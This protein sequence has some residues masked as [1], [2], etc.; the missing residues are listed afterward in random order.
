MKLDKDDII[1]H[2]KTTYEETLFTLL[3]EKKI[4]NTTTL[5]ES[6]KKELY[7]IYELNTNE[8]TITS[9]GKYYIDLILE[10]LIKE[11]VCQ[12]YVKFHSYQ[13]ITSKFLKL[14]EL[15]LPEQRSPEWYA[16]REN[17][18][19]ASSLAD[20]LGKGHFQTRDELLLNKSSQ[21]KKPFISHWIMEWGVKYEDVAIQFYEE[22]TGSRIMDF[23]LIPHP[24]LKVFGASP[25]GICDEMSPPNYVG[26]MLEIKCPPKRVFT[27]DVPEHY[28]MQIQGQLET[29]NL[30]ECDFFQVKILEYKTLKD[31]DED[32]FSINDVIQPGRTSNNLPK[33]S[34]IT[35]TIQENETC[36]Y[37]YKYSQLNQ[38]SDQL[39]EWASSIISS[40]SLSTTGYYKITQQWWYIERYECTLV[41]RDRQWWSETV[42][43]IIN[44][45]NEVEYFR[46]VGTGELEKRILE[47]KNKYKRKKITPTSPKQVD[48]SNQNYLLDSDSD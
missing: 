28:W 6:C 3:Q 34:V 19:T 5:Y 23:G 17:I 10:P 29:C 27:N 47:R 38:T 8:T 44:F 20:A 4:I 26:R 42:P 37:E 35:I 48:Y 11:F 31:Y 39:K 30:E 9:S 7:D 15:K 33:G 32:K 45:W 40:Y 25:D 43:H 41:Y 46:S 2:I 36:K 1:H 13:E 18:L 21:E 12:T 24:E 16:I 14:K 22:L